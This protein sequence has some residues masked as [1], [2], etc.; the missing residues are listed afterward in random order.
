MR[1]SPGV[2]HDLSPNADTSSHASSNVTRGIEALT[3]DAH[4]THLPRSGNSPRAYRAPA[5]GTGFDTPA[6]KSVVAECW[7]P[8]PQEE[9]I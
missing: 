2:E 7:L 4:T 1:R 6:A 9:R 8:G 5:K 3:G